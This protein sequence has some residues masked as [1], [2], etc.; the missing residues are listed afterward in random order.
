MSKHSN[1][2][3]IL[4][5]PLFPPAIHNDCIHLLRHFSVTFPGESEHEVIPYLL[6]PIKPDIQLIWL[7][8]DTSR[9]QYERVWQFTYLPSY[10]FY[11]LL[12][13]RCFFFFNQNFKKNMKI[14]TY[15][16]IKD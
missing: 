10:L 13:S 15:F 2:V 7:S 8:T 6:R 4:K 3:K 16:E 1:L 12:A 14:F 9:I 11:H 5:A